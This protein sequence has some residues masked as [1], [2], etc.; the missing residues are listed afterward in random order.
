MVK[1]WPR[2]VVLEPCKAH[3]DPRRQGVELVEVVREH[4]A[5]A[6]PDVAGAGLD[7]LIAVGPFLV[8][9]DGQSLTSRSALLNKLRTSRYR[10]ERS[11]NSSRRSRMQTR[12]ATVIP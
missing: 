10:S 7:Q 4:V 3:A 9:E 2:I 5:P 1:P 6:A 12:S 8:D 11:G